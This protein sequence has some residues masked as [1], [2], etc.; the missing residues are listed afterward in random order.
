MKMHTTLA[1]LAALAFALTAARATQPSP[2]APSAPA[3]PAAVQSQ[4][5][6]LGYHRFENPAKDP[7]AITTEEFR[8]QM[9]ALKDAGI[10]VISMEDFLAWRRGEKQ[11]PERSA[12][13][14][15]DDGYNCTYHIAWPILKE[16]GYPF[17]FF[18]YTNYINVGGRSITWDQ[19]REMQSQGVEIGSHSVSHDNMVRPK[20]SK[21]VEY[22]EWLRDEFRKSKAIIEEHLG[23]PVKTFAYP[24]GIQN[25]TVRQEGLDAGYEVLFTVAG[26]KVNR[27]EPAAAVGRYVIQ[28]GHP[29]IF[30]A[31]TSFGTGSITPGAIASGAVGS[32]PGVVVSPAHR[33]TIGEDRPEIRAELAPLGEIDPKTLEMRVSGLGQVKPEFDPATGVLRY[34]PAQRLHHRDITVSITTRVKGKKTETAWQFAIDPESLVPSAEQ[35]APPADMTTPPDSAAPAQS[36]PASAS[37]PQS[38]PPRAG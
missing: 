29:Q 30:R 33:E 27:E 36:L 20:R 35:L 24:Y 25:E 28:S 31:A 15:I 12:L 22:T 8:Q 5:T 18:V 17:T 16:Y 6:V 37:A 21:G 11:I 14:T 34:R 19:L 1:T 9:Q 3:T 7:L 23:V 10:T 38:L 4:V 2:S 13:I 26:K 32:A